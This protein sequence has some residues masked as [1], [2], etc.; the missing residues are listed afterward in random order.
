MYNVFF[1]ISFNTKTWYLSRL[2]CTNGTINS[3]VANI[4]YKYR[5]KEKNY[6]NKL[7]KNV[8]NESLASRYSAA[9]NKSE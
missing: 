3:R 2:L 6:K 8:K 4:S 5:K 7:A 1:F 9:K